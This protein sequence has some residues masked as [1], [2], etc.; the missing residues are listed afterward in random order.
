MTIQ[1]DPP[2]I[3]GI[4]L[5]FTVASLSIEQTRISGHRRNQ[6]LFPSGHFGR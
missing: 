5:L 6:H 4:Y 1:V 2:Q 3:L